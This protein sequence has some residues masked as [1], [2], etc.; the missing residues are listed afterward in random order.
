MFYDHLTT[1][2]VA[3]GVK[4]AALSRASGVSESTIRRIE[5]HAASTEETLTAL[6]NA[7]NETTHHKKKPIDPKSEIKPK[8]KFG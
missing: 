3:A 5:K 6:I 1:H 7:L 4:V 2:R 8:S